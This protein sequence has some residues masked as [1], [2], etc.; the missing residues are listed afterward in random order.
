MKIL[1]GCLNVN[2]LGGSELY[3]YELV[4]ELSKLGHNVTLFT[5]RNINQEDEVRLKL[6]DIRQLDLNSINT[7][8]QFDIIVASQLAS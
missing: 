5:L 7:T 6:G 4:R 3:H 1:I 2:G 8:E